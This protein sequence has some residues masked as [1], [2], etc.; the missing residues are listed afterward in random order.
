MKQT[1]KLKFIKFYVYGTLSIQ[2]AKS[3]APDEKSRTGCKYGSKLL[4]EPG[5]LQEIIRSEIPGNLGK[6]Y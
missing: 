4:R 6:D 5:K 3:S 1:G 2:V